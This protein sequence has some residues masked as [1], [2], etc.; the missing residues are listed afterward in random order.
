MMWRGVSTAVLDVSYSAL[1]ILCYSFPFII[2]LVVGNVVACVLAHW[3]VQW[4]T[5]S[6]S[7]SLFP[8]FSLLSCFLCK[9]PLVYAVT[10]DTPSLYPNK[11]PDP[12]DVA[13]CAFLTQPPPTACA[14]AVGLMRPRHVFIVRIHSLLDSG[15]LLLSYVSLSLFFFFYGRVMV[16]HFLLIFPSMLD[17]PAFDF[18]L[19]IFLFL[20]FCLQT[21]KYTNSSR[22]HVKECGVS[23]CLL[24]CSFCT[25]PLSLLL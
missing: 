6:L 3:L 11:T 10:D 2:F 25:A 7:L 20:L 19:P 5:L 16:S 13:L 12:I 4:N 9:V 22:L 24:R 17:N 21:H 15:S 14:R 1:T 18:L 8:F 23:S